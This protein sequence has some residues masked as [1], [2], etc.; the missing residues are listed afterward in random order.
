M[1]KLVIKRERK[2]AS[3]LLP[4]WVV[5][6]VSKEDL[7]YKYNMRKDKY[8]INEETGNYY[9][10]E[11]YEERIK[12]HGFGNA[13]VKILNGQTVELELDDTVQ[14]VFACTVDGYLTDEIRL[15]DYWIKDG[16]YEICLSTKGGLNNSSVPYFKPPK[17]SKHS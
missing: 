9:S 17:K 5:T 10:Q 16:H 2:L 7:M 3:A 1:I 4:Y 6:G 13:G 12:V 11:G 15:S 8:R 14:T